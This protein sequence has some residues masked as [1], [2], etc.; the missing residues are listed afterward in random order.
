MG[1][2]AD[3]HLT[4]GN[5]RICGVLQ[6]LIIMLLLEGTLILVPI[7]PSYQAEKHSSN[8]VCRA[9]HLQARENFQQIDVHPK[10]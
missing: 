10:N 9:W 8:P 5:P 1:D 3:M 7:I 4:L 2:D 6:R